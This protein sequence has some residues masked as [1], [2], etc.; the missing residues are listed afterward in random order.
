MKNLKSLELLKNRIVTQS[1]ISVADLGEGDNEMAFV[2]TH[3]R[4]SQASP[5]WSG[6]PC[7]GHKDVGYFGVD[8]DFPSDAVGLA[9]GADDRH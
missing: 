1:A 8:G 7:V 4:D 3:G 2:R 9:A 6:Q 5:V